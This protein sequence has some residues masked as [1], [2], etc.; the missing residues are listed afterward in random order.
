M[1]IADSYQ[2]VY[3]SCAFGM[4][5][6]Q[7]IRAGSHKS[8]AF[9]KK[10]RDSFLDISDNNKWYGLNIHNSLENSYYDPLQ[11]QSFFIPVTYDLRKSNHFY[12][13]RQYFFIK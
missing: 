4:H 1:F 3:F 5:R 12:V 8:Y 6:H 10:D 2:D 11:Q 13:H 9:L 7:E